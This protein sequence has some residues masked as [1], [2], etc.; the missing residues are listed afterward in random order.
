MC[1]LTSSGDPLGIALH[2]PPGNFDLGEPQ[3][4][5]RPFVDSPTV[6]TNDSL[7][8]W[9]D[10]N[11]TP[12]TLVMIVWKENA[13]GSDGYSSN[14]AVST[15]SQILDGKLCSLHMLSKRLWIFVSS[16]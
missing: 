12:T 5:I 6:L 11:V 16:M 2:K 14:A 13:F 4:M 3:S 15:R 10:G 9:I 1:F 7:E 8:K